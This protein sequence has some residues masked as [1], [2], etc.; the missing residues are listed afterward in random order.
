M[1]L[2]LRLELFQSFFELAFRADVLVVGAAATAS[3]VVVADAGALEKSA[4][5]SVAVGAVVL[6]FGFIHATSNARSKRFRMGWRDA[7]ERNNDMLNDG[8]EGKNGMGMGVADGG[9]APAP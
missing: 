4:V 7:A 8:E 1:L 3:A 5:V 2:H 9:D 6:A